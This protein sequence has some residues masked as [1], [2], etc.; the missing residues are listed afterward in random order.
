[1]SQGGNNTSP[2]L[3][4]MGLATWITVQQGQLGFACQRLPAN[5]EE[6]AFEKHPDMHSDAKWWYNVVNPMQTVVIAPGTIHSVLRPADA[7]T[8]A[9]GGHFLQWSDIPR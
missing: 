5:A 8:M 4:G 9:I 7:Y 6:E 2:H 1:M 3:D